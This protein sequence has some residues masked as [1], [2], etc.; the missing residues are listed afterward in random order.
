MLPIEDVITSYYLRMHVEDKPGVLADITRILADSGI[1]I[2]AL[3]Q[4][5]R[6]EG[7]T[8]RHH[9]AY[10]TRTVERNANAA[11]AKIEAL[12]VVQGKDQ[13]AHGKSVRACAESV[14]RRPY[15]R[16]RPFFWIR[17]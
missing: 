5:K 16:V 1:S 8:H 9:P 14:R 13:A 2:E 7:D 3:I 11:I 17:G 10:L 12:P 15:P 6:S 4:L